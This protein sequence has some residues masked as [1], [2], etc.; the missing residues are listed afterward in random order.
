VAT[1]ALHERRGRVAHNGLPDVHRGGASAC[2]HQ[3]S[4]GRPHRPGE[5]DLDRER[6]LEELSRGYEGSPWLTLLVNFSGFLAVFAWSFVA[7]I[8]LLNLR[9]GE[10]WLPY[11]LVLAALVGVHAGLRAVRHYRRRSTGHRRP[12]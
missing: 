3:F 12:E 11:A 1:L 2:F 6:R 8:L 9:N 10:A 4:P 5:E 7:V